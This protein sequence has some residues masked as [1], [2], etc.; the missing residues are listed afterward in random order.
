MSIFIYGFIGVI[1]LIFVFQIINSVAIS[2]SARLREYGIM[3]AIGAESRQITRM[4]MAQAV[5]Y[6][7]FGILVGTAV[8]IPV[9]RLLYTWIITTRWGAAWRMP[10]VELFLI[11]GIIAASCIGAVYRPM[12]EIRNMSVVETLTT[13]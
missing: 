11:A 3:Q 8:G 5:A 4:V 13:F 10:T 9:N 1:A 7:I 2:V 6:G 12:K